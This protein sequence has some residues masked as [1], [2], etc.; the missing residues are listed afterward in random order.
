MA[1]ALGLLEEKGVEGNASRLIYYCTAN[2]VC[3]GG[4]DQSYMG[5]HRALAVDRRTLYRT[6]CEIGGLPCTIMGPKPSG[7]AS[8]NLQ[9]GVSK[10]IGSGGFL[11]S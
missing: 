4:N 11:D 1:S 2:R 7:R 9:M 3:A 10:S 5:A 8:L 6:G